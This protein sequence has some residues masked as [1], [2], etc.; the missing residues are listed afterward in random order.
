[1]DVL[2]IFFSF[3]LSFATIVLAWFTCLLYKETKKNREFNELLNEPELS[4]ILYFRKS[5][6]YISIKNIGKS[7]IFNLKLDKLEGDDI[8]TLNN[9]KLSESK[10][11][12]KINYLR[13]NQEINSLIY[14][15]TF[16]GEKFKLFYSFNNIKNQRKRK[17]FNFDLSEFEDLSFNDGDLDNELNHNLKQ[18]KNSIDKLKTQS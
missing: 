2:N 4:I 18:I 5:F 6:I 16:K 3:V 7:P 14:K 1:M 8:K 11:L 13:P 12:N 10:F 17:V 9:K 15:I